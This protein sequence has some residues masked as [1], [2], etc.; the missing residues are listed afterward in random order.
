MPSCAYTEAMNDIIDEIKLDLLAKGVSQRMIDDAEKL[1]SEYR[2]WSIFEATIHSNPLVLSNTGLRMKL[3]SQRY[4]PFVFIE[5]KQPRDIAL[6]PDLETSEYYMFNTKNAECLISKSRYGTSRL[7][8]SDGKTHELIGEFRGKNMLSDLYKTGIA[9]GLA[10][11]NE[12]VARK[13]SV[14]L[15]A[16]LFYGIYNAFSKSKDGKKGIMIPD[17]NFSSTLNIIASADLLSQIGTKLN[18]DIKVIAPKNLPKHTNLHTNSDS[19]DKARAHTDFE[20]IW[21]FNELNPKYVFG[22]DGKDLYMVD[23]NTDMACKY[24]KLD[25]CWSNTLEI[26]HE[27]RSLSLPPC[28]PE[29]NKCNSLE[30]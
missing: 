28:S 20:L 27:N 17:Q 30:R 4:S 16:P 10:I 21:A 8:K 12:F 2:I 7:W 11:P 25:Q 13:V 5:N 19:L 1:G 26:D 29:K 9:K 24:E 3:I 23:K 15:I 22:W 6:L 18:D 14:Y